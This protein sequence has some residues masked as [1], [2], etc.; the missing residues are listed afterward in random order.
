MDWLEKS[1]SPGRLTAS[2]HLREL[3]KIAAVKFRGIDCSV[4]A[5]Q[6]RRTR[7]LEAIAGD[8]VERPALARAAAG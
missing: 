3:R 2:D 5:D 4:L 7:A 1:D 6:Y 8:A